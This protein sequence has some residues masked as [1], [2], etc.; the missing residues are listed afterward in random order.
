MRLDTRSLFEKTEEL[1]NE[2]SVNRVVIIGEL[3]KD[4]YKTL[5][6]KFSPIYYSVKEEV[7][8]SGDNSEEYKLHIT[9]KRR[10]NKK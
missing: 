9:K 8:I 6:E 4:D 5:I 10:I 7:S 1:L 2:K 3:G